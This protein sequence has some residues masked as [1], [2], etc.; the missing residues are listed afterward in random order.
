MIARKNKHERQAEAIDAYRRACARRPELNIAG[1]LSFTSKIGPKKYVKTFNL[2]LES[3][4]CREEN[5]I[6]SPVCEANCYCHKMLEWLSVAARAEKNFEL[7]QLETF[8][9]I[10]IGAILKSAPTQMKLHAMGDFFSV[11]YI[12]SWRAV[13]G[14]C[15]HVDFWC[16]TRAWGLKEMVPALTSL[17]A[18]PN[19]CMLLSF[20]RS[21]R[22]PPLIPY[23]RLAWLADTDAEIP[24]AESA[25][26]FR[27]R[28]NR[29]SIQL[30]VLGDSLVCPHENG[31]PGGPRDCVTCRV[32]L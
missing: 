17:A 28:R 21:M 27:A 8:S 5:P 2:S 19:M 1:C 26:V 6:A 16:Y 11:N 10:M 25:V 4:C 31:T 29:D 18:L 32:C 30:K 9:Q 13:V 14:E 20:D 15:E 22:I 7:A 3:T 12:D 23:T 24:L